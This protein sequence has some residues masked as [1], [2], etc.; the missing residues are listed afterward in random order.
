CRWAPRVLACVWLVAALGSPS[1]AGETQQTGQPQSQSWKLPKG[2]TEPDLIRLLVPDYDQRRKRSEENRNT[3]DLLFRASV[4]EVLETNLGFPGKRYLLFAVSG[5]DGICDQCYFWHIGILDLATRTIIFRH[6][7]GGRGPEPTLKVFRLSGDDRRLCLSF[8]DGYTSLSAGGYSL[9]TEEWYRPSSQADGTLEFDHIW[10][11]LIENTHTNNFGAW[12]HV[13]SCGR[14]MAA[15][16]SRLYEYRQKTSFGILVSEFEASPV[17]PDPAWQ[18]ASECDCEECGVEIRRVEQWAFDRHG[19]RLA[20][21]S[22]SVFRIDDFP[23]AGF[24]FDLPLRR[25]GFAPVGTRLPVEFGRA[26]QRTRVSSP[27]GDRQVIWEPFSATETLGELRVTS[28]TSGEV[29]RKVAVPRDPFVG[30]IESIGWETSGDRFFVVVTI[31]RPRL[32]ELSGAGKENRALLSFGVPGGEDYWE[33]LVKSDSPL[34]EYGFVLAP[35][36]KLR[37]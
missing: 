3:G 26:D 17:A 11:G 31:G 5:E 21:R 35:T 22:E 10:S 13:S 27:V 4:S 25:I 20:R 29:L 12:E 23:V 16:G 6:D 15:P 33:D 19:R 2:M 34:L 28:L 37:S 7:H 30:G 1:L 9:T 18:W 24:P 14:M 36:R 8:R 32:R